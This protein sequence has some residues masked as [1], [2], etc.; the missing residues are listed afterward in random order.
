[1]REAL[2]QRLVA[3]PVAE[4]PFL[5]ETGQPRDFEAISRMHAKAGAKCQT[6]VRHV[7]HILRRHLG[8]H[9]FQFDAAFIR[10]GCF[11][12]GFLLAGEGGSTEDIETCLQALREMR[13]TF[14][15]CEEREH[16]LRMIW[17]SKMAQGRSRSF[18]TTSPHEDLLRPLDHP[19]SRRSLARPISVPPL[20]L[21]LSTVPLPGP[22]SAP[23]TACPNSAWPLSSTPPSSSG[24]GM[25]EGSVSSDR[26]SPTSPFSHHAPDNLVLDAGLHHKAGLSSHPS[27]SFD[28]GHSRGTEP[29]MDGVFYWQAYTGYGANGELLGTQHVPS[30]GL[31][32]GAADSDFA[33]SQYFDANSVVFPNTVIGQSA[34]QGGSS[35]LASTG[36]D[37]RQ[38]GNNSL[39]P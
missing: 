29:G 22:A 12:A 11:F 8:T 20:S 39:Y 30:T 27:L 13:W 32:S 17:E 28:H 7:V 10:D 34:V 6:V 35:D 9:F 18:T 26:A 19:Y 38:F 1:M 4:A 37:A 3:R 24:T 31:L 25:Y 14:S 36:G 21:S 23:S 33:S 5:P 2:K 16:T 15:K